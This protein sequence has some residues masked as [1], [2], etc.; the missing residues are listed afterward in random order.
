M[1]RYATEHPTLDSHWKTNHTRQDQ[2]QDRQWD[3]IEHSEISR[4]WHSQWLSMISPCDTEIYFPNLTNSDIQTCLPFFPA[5]I[6]R[7]YWRERRKHGGIG[8]IT[9]TWKGRDGTISQRSYCWQAK[10]GTK[11]PG[12]ERDQTNIPALKETRHPIEG[13]WG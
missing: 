13:Y 10:K 8:W 9:P 12:F 3:Y 4:H 2:R 6:A 5:G 1:S 11:H 7:V